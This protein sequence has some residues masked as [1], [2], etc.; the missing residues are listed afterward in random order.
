MITAGDFRKGV[1]FVIDNYVYIIVEFLHVKP[2]KGAAFVRTKIKNVMTGQVIERTFNPNEK[3]ELAQIERKELQYLYSDEDLYYFMDTNTYEQYPF[4]KDVVEDALKFVKEG[5][6][7]QIS[8]FKG[9]AFS[10]EPPTFVELEITVCDPAVQGDTS[11]AGNKSATVET[12]F[13][14]QVPMFVALGDTIRVDTRTGTYM[15]RV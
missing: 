1:T 6:N 7:L 14:L 9:K 12:G 4:N 13:V 10:V 11:K 5:M 8:F 15:E 2:G 3:F